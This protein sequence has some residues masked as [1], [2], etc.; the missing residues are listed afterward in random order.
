MAPFAV[1]VETFMNH[2]PLLFGRFLVKAG[3]VTEAQM[4]RAIRLQRQHQLG[5]GVIALLDGLLS[6]DDFRRLLAHQRQTGQL[7]EEAV[8]ELDLLDRTDL[9][10]LE[11]RGKDIHLLL[12]E[13]LVVQG[14]MSVDQ[15]Q[16]ALDAFHH[17]TTTGLLT[18]NA[19]DQ[20]LLTGKMHES[21]LPSGAFGS[22]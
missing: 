14:S 11:S 5:P 1:Q 20:D 13:A 3:W 22:G 18:R 10:H 17:Y 4:N 12:G 9:A 6:L 21:C 2:V 7:F 19:Q 8:Q 15:L 16:D